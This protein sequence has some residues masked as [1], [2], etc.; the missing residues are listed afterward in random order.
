MRPRIRGRQ[1]ENR[2]APRSKKWGQTTF[3]VTRFDRLHHDTITVELKRGLT[4]FR[5]KTW[6]DPDLPIERFHSA[7]TFK[8]ADR[9]PSAAIVV[10]VSMRD[11]SEAR[12][13]TM[14]AMSMGSPDENG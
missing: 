5:L 4:P 13:T 6:S 7:Y 10:P 3:S 14:W 9:P 12:N 2:A 1:D 8:Y 11:S